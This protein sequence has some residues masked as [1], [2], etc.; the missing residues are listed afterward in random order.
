MKIILPCLL[1]CF[2]CLSP[3]YCQISP[4][5]SDDIE[6]FADILQDQPFVKPLGLTDLSNSRFIIHWI[7]PDRRAS[8]TFLDRIG[9]YAG[10]QNV[11]IQYHW[12]WP[13]S[14]ETTSHQ[15]P[16]VVYDS[17]M[18]WPSRFSHFKGFKIRIG[19]K[20]SSSFD[21]LQLNHAGLGIIDLTAQYIMNGIKL[22]DGG[23]IVTGSR[24][25]YLSAEYLGV[26]ENY[27]Y[28]QLDSI[29]QLGLDSAAYPGAQVSIVYKGS[30]IYQKSVG[31]HTFDK[32]YRVR[33][34][35][36]W[37]LASVTKIT[38]GVNSLMS[39]YEDDVFD[40][41]KTLGDYFSEFR[42]SDKGDLTMKRILTHSAGLIPYMVYYAMIQ[43]ENGKYDRNTLARTRHGN[44]NYAVTDSIYVSDKFQDFI[45][46][47]IRES[48]LNPG[49]KYEYSGLFF[50]MIKELVIQQTGT[51]LDV[52]L[53]RKV[54]NPLGANNTAFNPSWSY[55]LH[56][57]IPTE[58]DRVWR[59]QL[60]HG[61]VHDEA[62]AVLGGVSANAG[63]F[64]T[65]SD[66]IKIGE[67]W[68]RS[69]QFGGKTY[70]SPE[71]IRTFTQC[72]YCD[73][74]N[75]RALG[76]DRPPLPEQDYLSYMSPLASQ[77]S[78]GHSGFTGTMLWVDPT[79]EYTFVFLSNRVHPTRE[80]TKLY[81]LDIRPK[82]HSV[83]YKAIE[84]RKINDDL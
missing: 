49:N 47:S 45:F 80:N 51:P 31:Y 72:Y 83:L 81:S 16:L 15:I 11:N 68:R 58:F 5:N 44:F 46:E 73:E 61:S 9:C 25:S 56:Q 7:Y 8:R 59:H 76:F 60:V 55:N 62:S 78:F 42:N 39:M 43:K 12:N 32:V 1:L 6:T 40:L 63:L 26:D 30:V 21:G 70:W 38:A 36:M 69:G 52:Y 33:N 17:D 74:G 37:D 57:I 29:L 35:D 65:G 24:V 28:E 27:L 34:H 53:D 79:A 50:Q 84:R 19:P 77:E 66:L 13:D 2:A 4:V 3:I 71:T 48:T 20:D 67:T 23:N 64:S 82:L 10:D 41:D 54:F 14:L 18:T 75:R 22:D